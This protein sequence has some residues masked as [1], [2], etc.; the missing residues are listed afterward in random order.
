MV[1]SVLIANVLPLYGL[2][3]LGFIVGKGVKL[4]VQPIAT[5][6][7]YAVLPIVMFGA[8]GNMEFTAE[9]FLPP[10]IIASISIVA[11]GTAYL[12]S[13]RIWGD[14]RHNLLGLLGTGGN[15]T[16]FGIP[17]ALAMFGEEWLSVF[18]LMVLPLFIVECTLGYYYAVRGEST[19]KD[20]L[21][22]VAKLP[23]IHGALLG[24]CVSLA[25]FELPELFNEYWMR[26]TNTTII[27]GMMMIGA[28]LAR[29]ENFRFD[30]SFF[31]GV[32]ALRYVLWPVFGFAWVAFDV[33][34]LQMLPATVHSMLI[35]VCSCPLAANNV[36]YAARLNL[37]P[38]LTA[39]M[40]LV[41]TLLALA[42]IP[43]TLMVKEGLF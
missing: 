20:S 36:A 29:M 21:I 27:L 14:K 22:R 30:W 16:Y 33:F 4:D 15:G 24:L 12:V 38:A 40:V 5:I 25:G 9:Y 26:F 11:S 6:M 34:Y 39:A 10:L 2:I 3:L 23:I 8:T 43:F 7:L 41:T 31:G 19:I 17:I 32:L 35:L 42:F 37:H 13:A 28:A 18:I 1:F